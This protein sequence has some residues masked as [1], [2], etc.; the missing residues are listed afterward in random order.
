M[1]MRRRTHG[2]TKS[3]EL[4]SYGGIQG[5]HEANWCANASRENEVIASIVKVITEENESDILTRNVND[6]RLFQHLA[7]DLLSGNLRSR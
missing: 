7:M 5:K 2:K 1:R 6:E 4:E 3:R